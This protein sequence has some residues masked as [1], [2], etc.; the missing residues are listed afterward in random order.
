MG[1][2]EWTMK[3]TQRGQT[4]LYDRAKAHFDTLW[5]DDE[6]T[7]FKPDDPESRTALSEALLREG[8]YGSV[9]VTTFFDIHPKPYQREMLDQLARE[10][11]HGRNRNL[12]VAATGTG[13][14]VVAALDYRRTVEQLGHRPRLL[15]VAHRAQILR[16]AMRTYREVLR[17]HS[18]GELL[19]GGSQPLQHDHLFASIDT[20]STRDIVE[21]FGADYW[22]TVVIDEGHRIAADRFHRFATTV[23]PAQLLGLTATP[24]RTDGQSIAKYF[25][26]LR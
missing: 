17:D 26:P 19:A 8:G 24:E 16:Q 1:G 6:F 25:T 12:V 5:L 2:L 4:A 15:L 13:K 11:E 22:H 10:R 14:P 3:F 7:P 23:E 20:V 9:G 18:F 21:R